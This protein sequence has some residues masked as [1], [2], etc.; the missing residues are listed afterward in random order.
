MAPPRENGWTRGYSP[1]RSLLPKSSRRL[2][3]TDDDINHLTFPIF[4]ILQRHMRGKIARFY[5]YARS[6]ID[7]LYFTFYAREFY[8]GMCT[9][10]TVEIHPYSGDLNLVRLKTSQT[11]WEPRES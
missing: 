6:F 9:Y 8:A 1:I 7:G 5:V 4:D 10:A 3:H 11:P 2:K